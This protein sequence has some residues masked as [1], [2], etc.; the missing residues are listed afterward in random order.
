[1]VWIAP[2]GR[3]FD[4]IDA[5]VIYEYYSEEDYENDLNESY[6]DV[7]IAGHAYETGLALRAVDPVAFSTGYSESLDYFARDPESLGFEEV[8]EDDYEDD[9]DSESVRSA[10]TSAYNKGR[11]G[12]Q[13]ATAKTKAGVQKAK[14]KAKTKKAPAKKT[15]P[16]SASPRSTKPKAPAKK[17][18]C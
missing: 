6:G 16:K 1:M 7:V 4:D 10:M 9:D 5:D 15:A 8:D 11:A 18:R 17:G 13:K 14:A 3:E 2:D 12:V